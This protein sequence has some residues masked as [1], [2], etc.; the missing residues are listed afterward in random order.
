MSSSAHANNRANNILV[1]D[2]EFI[3]GVNDTTIY[4]EKMYSTNFTVTDKIF[5]LSLH[6]K[7]DS[8]YLFVNDKEIVNFKANESEIVPY[9]LF[10]KTF[11]Q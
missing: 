2:K 6:Y 11:L 3:Q 10:Q 1:L 8:S 5:C 9:L 7:G 4:A